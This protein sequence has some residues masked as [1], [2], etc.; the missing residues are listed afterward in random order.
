MRCARA[1]SNVIL[2]LTDEEKGLAV[3]ERM[4]PSLKSH[5][6][7]LVPSSSLSIACQMVLSLPRPLG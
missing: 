6:L 7:S 1:E 2:R 5:F 4:R 3:G